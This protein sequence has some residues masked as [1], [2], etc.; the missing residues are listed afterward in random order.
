MPGTFLVCPDGAAVSYDS[1]S[2]VRCIQ[3]GSVAWELHHTS[4]ITGTSEIFNIPETAEL[5]LAFL[6]SFSLIMIVH[7]ASWAYG[8][9][10]N[11]TEKENHN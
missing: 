2:R 3:D 1:L 7:L 8:K 5:Q 4:E 6:T 11:F 10:I 9:V